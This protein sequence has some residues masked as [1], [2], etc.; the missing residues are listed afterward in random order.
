MKAVKIK[1]LNF[2]YNDTGP[3]LKNISLE[4]DPGEKVALIG[5]NGA[6]KTSL[7]FQLNGILQGNFEE[8]EILGLSL[9]D[10]KNFPKVRELVAIVFQDPGDQLFMPTVF[11]DIAFAPVQKGIS[12]E[13]LKNL[14][15]AEREKVGL[16]AQIENKMAH[17]LSLG[18]K[19]KVTLAAVLAQKPEILVLDEPTASMDPAGV[20]ELLEILGQFKK[21]IILA[22][23]N[24]A[25]VR[26]TCEKIIF[27]NSGKMVY[28]GGADILDDEQFLRMHG[29]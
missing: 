15:S 28:F 27:L 7:I 24:L 2:S 12:G 3:V 16:P 29:L 9:K 23:H 13:P 25:L 19:R 8:L 20:R 21:T 5:P 1:N 4:I 22:S 11:E 14:V 10:K 26:K 18:E 17:H 6:G